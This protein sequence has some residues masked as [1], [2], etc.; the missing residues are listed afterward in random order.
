MGGMGFIHS[1]NDPIIP[2]DNHIITIN[3]IEVAKAIGS[4]T[5]L[6]YASSACVY[7]EELQQVDIANES[8]QSCQ[9]NQTQANDHVSTSRG[10]CL[11]E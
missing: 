2:R 3:I 1:G 6:F 11:E 7:P 9:V 4:I 8:S 10:R 5:S